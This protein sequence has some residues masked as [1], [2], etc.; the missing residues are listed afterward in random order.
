MLSLS[1]ELRV[2]L[3]DFIQFEVDYVFAVARGQCILLTTVR[4]L[5]L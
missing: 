2:S 5:V 3:L 4:H 1:V